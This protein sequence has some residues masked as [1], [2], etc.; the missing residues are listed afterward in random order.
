M[1]EGE[2]E[3]LTL[4]V[5]RIEY[6]LSDE[7]AFST[8]LHTGQEYDGELLAQKAVIDRLARESISRGRS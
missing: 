7:G 3:T 8:R 1:P 5:K 2:T 6:V 4:D